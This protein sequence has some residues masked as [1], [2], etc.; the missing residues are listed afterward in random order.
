MT[1]SASLCLSSSRPA[2]SHCLSIHTD[3]RLCACLFYR[4]ADNRIS[5]RTRKITPAPRSSGSGG[6]LLSAVICGNAILEDHVGTKK[7]TRHLVIV[8]DAEA[9]TQW[10]EEDLDASVRLM[11]QKGVVLSIV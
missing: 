9:P 10:S 1:A 11:K 5:D 8:T 4:T 3:H 6:D 2:L 7:R